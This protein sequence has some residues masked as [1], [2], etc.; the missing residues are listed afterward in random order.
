M[1]QQ[2]FVLTTIC[3]GSKTKQALRPGSE[4]QVQILRKHI[5]RRGSLHH[6]CLCEMPM[7]NTK[8]RVC[9]ARGGC[10]KD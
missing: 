4:I 5:Y 2:D 6:T 8:K 9:V 3:V 10:E 1:K 7:E